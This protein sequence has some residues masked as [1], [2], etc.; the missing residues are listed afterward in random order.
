MEETRPRKRFFNFTPARL[1]RLLTSFLLL[2]GLLMPL[3][4]AFGAQ[5]ALGAALL[6]GTVILCVFSVLGSFRHG[7]ILLLLAVL[8]AAGT[9]LLLPRLGFFGSSLQAVRAIALYFRD[10]ES[11]APM[12]AREIGLLLGAVLPVAAYL[13]SSRVSG[14]LP[15]TILMAMML[16][17]LCSL[18]QM[19]Y[20]WYSA[21][22]FVALL[23]LISQVSHE[24]TNILEVLPMAAVVVALAMLLLPAGKTVIEPLYEKAMD[25]KQRITDYLFFTDEREIFTIGQYGYYPLLES[26]NR[27]GGDA[28]PN[29]SAV[30]M[31]KTDKKALLRGISKDYYN[32]ATWENTYDMTR[33]LYVN[34]RAASLRREAFAE[35]LPSDAAKRLS[36]ALDEKAVSVQIEGGAASTLFVPVGLR[37]FSASG[38]LVAYFNERGEL[39]TTHDLTQGERYTAFAPVTEGGESDLTALMSAL[40]ASARSRDERFYERHLQVPDHIEQKLRDDARDIVSGCGSDYEKACAILRHLKRYYSYTLTPGPGSGTQDFVTNFLY[41]TR[42]GYCVHFA[43]AMTLL[44]RLADVPARYVEGFLCN[45]AAD[46]IAY[47]TGKNAH[48]W[49]EV[50]IE[51]FGWVPFDA[52]PAQKDDDPEPPPQNEPEP[53]PTPTPPP[54]EDEDDTPPEPTPTPDPDAAPP[55]DA[56]DPPPDET[57]P[58]DKP[59][60]PWWI[61]LILLAAALIAARLIQT[62]PAAV[63]AKETTHAG[64]VMVC[65]SALAALA[66]LRGV[67]P[68]PSDTP[69]RFA[70]RVDRAKIMPES[71][72]PV[73]RAMAA[74]NY[75]RA[76]L[77]EQDAK[78]AQA[79][80]TRCLKAQKPLTRLRFTLKNALSRHPFRA[81]ETD[82]DYAAP[83]VRYD[84]ALA[85]ERLKAAGANT[86]RRRKKK[87][88]AEPKPLSKAE[89][90]AREKRFARPEGEP[91]PELPPEPVPAEGNAAE[92]I[93]PDFTAV[94]ENAAPAGTAPAGE[95]TL[96]DFTAVPDDPA[97]AFAAESDMD[98]LEA[99]IRRAEEETPPMAA[100][101]AA[102]AG[103]ETM[104]P[105]TNLPDGESDASPARRRRRG[106][107]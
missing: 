96:P 36:H 95:N 12:F 18:G 53:T 106:R 68:R 17:V 3:M 77:T 67:K 93:L 26:E 64:S 85:A 7:R 52:T 25:L 91:K 8:A 90:L 76:D 2:A 37:S 16:F 6:E 61:L 73:W 23:L 35:D 5:S 103:S 63:A 4:F 11:A 31:V 15:A 83:E 21:P 55:Q 27:M 44:C 101:E 40:P 14:F 75:G 19:R 20:I 87:R 28:E 86:S 80:L 74:A 100:P 98:A 88:Q 58:E 51:G 13:F 47:V 65:G 60:F 71:V 81:L 54:P 9:Q 102:D 1:S 59:P 78:D 66:A 42:S 105:E 30:M 34:R 46:G 97:A 69:L 62:R 89:R 24:S 45:P 79:L 49:C 50:W 41:V 70:R 39:F 92:S 72:L 29:G 32:G 82:Y 10:V 99:E 104:I 43:S 56:D 38:S 33:Y 48:A 57:P 22:A 84:Y 94:P 107:N